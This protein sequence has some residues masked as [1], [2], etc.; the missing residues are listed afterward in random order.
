[1]IT[2]SLE[3]ELSIEEEDIEITSLFGVAA[4]VLAAIAGA[5][6]MR[7]TGRMP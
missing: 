7:W 5:L 4:L 2:N 3:R 6:S 1:M